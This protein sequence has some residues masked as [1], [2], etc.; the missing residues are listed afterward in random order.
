MRLSSKQ[1][2]TLGDIAGHG[3]YFCG[4]GGM[5]GLHLRTVQAL[6]LRGLAE[7]YNISSRSEIGPQ[8]GL[9]LCTEAECRIT[10]A[11]REWLA[12]AD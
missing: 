1:I 5:G 3:S 12:T 9:N 6:A 10:D 2:E 11:G 7:V 8:G 4:S